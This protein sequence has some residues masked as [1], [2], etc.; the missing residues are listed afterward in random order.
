MKG[1]VTNRL[2]CLH[3]GLYPPPQVLHLT[4]SWREAPLALEVVEVSKWG[5][6]ATHLPHLP[7][8]PHLRLPYPKWKPYAP[9]NIIFV[10]IFNRHA[11]ESLSIGW[12]RSKISITVWYSAVLSERAFKVGKPKGPEGSKNACTKDMVARYGCIAKEKGLAKK[13]AG[14]VLLV[15]PLIHF[16]LPALRYLFEMQ[17]LCPKFYRGFVE[18]AQKKDKKQCDM[19]FWHRAEAIAKI[20]LQKLSWPRWQVV[21]GLEKSCCADSD[22]LAITVWP[23]V[24][25]PYGH[26]A[27]QCSAPPGNARTNCCKLTIPQTGVVILIR[28]H[29]FWMLVRALSPCQEHA[30]R[31]LMLGWSA[32][33]RKVHGPAEWESWC[34][35]QFRSKHPVLLKRSMLRS[36]CIQEIF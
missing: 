30:K 11:F 18:A 36:D 16:L 13:I 5:L 12:T 28:P 21:P 2:W 33:F 32:E 27:L 4:K 1:S 24:Q 8:L 3:G 9:W 15:C 23:A 14:S 19:H 20:L 34:C 17:I 35:F 25:I 26:P 31:P 29:S 7:H 22:R 10:Y 6:Q